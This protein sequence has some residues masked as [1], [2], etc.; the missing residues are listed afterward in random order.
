MIVA[1]DNELKPTELKRQ[2][3]SGF[4]FSGL[5]FLIRFANIHATNKETGKASE[6]ASAN[7]THPCSAE[8]SP[9]TAYA[10]ASPRLD[11][12]T[13]GQNFRADIFPTPQTV[14]TPRPGQATRDKSLTS[15]F[16][17][18]SLIARY[19]LT[20]L[21]S[22]AALLTGH[23][24]RMPTSNPPHTR[25]SIQSTPPNFPKPHP[26]F[27]RQSFQ[28]HSTE[29]AAEYRLSSTRQPPKT[30]TRAAQPAQDS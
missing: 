7:P 30:Q 26:G 23:P 21:A 8:I 20:I 10:I 4:S 3:I 19:P 1:A 25:D 22:S 13:T 28:P 15:R 27:V 6:I 18:T 16:P 14:P 12:I 2:R 5:S 24:T 9:S 17:N 29:P 11:A